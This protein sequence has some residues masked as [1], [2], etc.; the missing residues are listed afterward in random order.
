MW[1]QDERLPGDAAGQ[2]VLSVRFHDGRYFEYSGNTEQM[3]EQ[4]RAWNPADVDAGIC[5]LSRNLSA[6]SKS[7]SSSLA[8]C[9]FTS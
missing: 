7:V 3:V 1:S 5:A 4:I 9:R 2:S 6:F 8:M